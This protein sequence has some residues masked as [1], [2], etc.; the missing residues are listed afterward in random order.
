MWVL[1][2]LSIQL[3]IPANNGLGD[4]LCFWIKNAVDPTI[5]HINIRL[6]HTFLSCRRLWKPVLPDVT[7]VVARRLFLM[8]IIETIVALYSFYLVRFIGKLLL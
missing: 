3:G 6:S 2:T 5:F 7:K 1:R 8:R 4:F